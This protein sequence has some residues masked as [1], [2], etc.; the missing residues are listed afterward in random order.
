MGRRPRRVHRRLK[1]RPRPPAAP[2]AAGQTSAGPSARE[3][4][5]AAGER[6]CR[7]PCRAVGAHRL[8]W[9]LAVAADQTFADLRY[10][11]PARMAPRLEGASELRASPCP[12]RRRCRRRAPLRTWRTT[13][14]TC[15]V[16]HVVRYGPCSGS[17]AASPARPARSP[18]Q[19]GAHR[20]T[21]LGRPPCPR[22]EP[23][24]SRT[25]RR[26]CSTTPDADARHCLPTRPPSRPTSRR[27]VNTARRRRADCSR[28]SWHHL[29][30]SRIGPELP[31]WIICAAAFGSR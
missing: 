21:Y 23:R 28:N 6:R 19:S 12:L 20:P 8:C 18:R 7:R 3:L 5:W 2:P 26:S 30:M 27:R 25:A 16:R 17:L 10:P 1:A 24:D 31:E 15:L 13:S 29:R 14:R 4:R 11:R 22:P 9:D